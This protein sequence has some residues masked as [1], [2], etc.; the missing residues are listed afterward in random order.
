MA[1]C[2][3]LTTPHRQAVEPPLVGCL[4]LLI[5]YI[6][7]TLHTGGCSSIHNLRTHHAVLTGTHLPWPVIS[8]NIHKC[9][10]IQNNFK[11]YY[12]PTNNGDCGRSV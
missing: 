6:A 12:V 9:A 8:P 10:Y 5:Q 11:M 7:A 1:S 2:C 3:L 4:Q